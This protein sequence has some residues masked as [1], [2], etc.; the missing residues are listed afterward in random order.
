MLLLFLQNTIEMCTPAPQDNGGVTPLSPNSPGSTLMGAQEELKLRLPS[1]EN[2]KQ[3]IYEIYD[4]RIFHA[5]E[6][7]GAINTSYLTMEEHLIL[8]FT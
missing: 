5:P 4:H 6:I 2:F 1:W 3:L 7:N 8:F